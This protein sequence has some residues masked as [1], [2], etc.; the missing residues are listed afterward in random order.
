MRLPS[1]VSMTLSGLAGDWKRKRSVHVSCPGSATSSARDE[2][3][4]DNGGEAVGV[5]RE[6]VCE[7]VDEAEEEVRGVK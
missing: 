1:G 2:G 5:V 6:V 4:T 7:L 3:A